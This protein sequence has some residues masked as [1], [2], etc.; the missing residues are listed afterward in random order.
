MNIRDHGDGAFEYGRGDCDYGDE[1]V[2]M[3]VRVCECAWTSS[4]THPGHWSM[5]SSIPPSF[6]LSEGLALPRDQARW[7]Q[8]C[9]PA[10]V[11]ALPPCTSASLLN[12]LRTPIA[13]VWADP[14][15]SLTPG[16]PPPSATWCPP[17]AGGAGAGRGMWLAVAEAGQC[18]EDGDR[19][20]AWTSRWERLSQWGPLSPFLRM[21]GWGLGRGSQGASV[22]GALPRVGQ[23]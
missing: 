17:T 15:S 14:E 5:W 16:P 10:T 20:L 2:N 8:H 12:R 6:G 4:P 19:R 21:W 23:G 9:L 3:E 11:L 7:E 22:P 13:P 1:L 18:L